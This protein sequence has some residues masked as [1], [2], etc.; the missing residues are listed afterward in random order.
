MYSTQK[1][2]SFKNLRIK[3]LF[4]KTS[5]RNDDKESKDERAAWRRDRGYGVLCTGLQGAAGACVRQRCHGDG[6]AS[7]LELATSSAG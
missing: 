4:F 1:I 3:C 2:T 5:F 7:L 6:R